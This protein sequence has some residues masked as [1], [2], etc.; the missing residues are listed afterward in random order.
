MPTS[1]CWI[2]SRTRHLDFTAPTWRLSSVPTDHSRRQR[3]GC[4]N[5]L[6]D[7]EPALT[8]HNL[9]GAIYD[10]PSGMFDARE[11]STW[12]TQGKGRHGP[13]KER[14][15]ADEWCDGCHRDDQEGVRLPN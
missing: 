13:H 9:S 14:D 12:P 5:S 4:A 11:S 7:Q 15:D 1:K 10:S 3:R 6:G 2:S 8:T